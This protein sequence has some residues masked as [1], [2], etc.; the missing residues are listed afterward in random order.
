MSTHIDDIFDIIANKRVLCIGDLMLDRYI[1]G[2][3]KRISP[4][5]PIPILRK[6][7]EREMLGAVGN[8]ARNVVSLGGKVTL[9]SVV[10]DDEIGRRLA[11]LIA[12]EE[13][14]EGDLIPMRDRRTTLKT[15]FVANGQQLLRV[16][17][18]DSHSISAHDEEDLIRAIEE[19]TA[20]CDAVLVSDYA[21]G[22]VTSNVLAAV[23]KAA[24]RHGKP[25]VADPKGLDFER[26]G[27]VDLLKPNA[28]ELSAALNM[29]T[30]TDED[31]EKALNAASERYPAKAVLVTRSSKGLSYLKEDGKIVHLRSKPLEVY[32]V[33]GAGDTSL[34]ALGLGVA[35]GV[36]MHGVCEL[37]LAA[38]S[39][40]VTKVGTAA[41]FSEE[42]KTFVRGR[43]SR[44]DA[45]DKVMNLEEA[46]LQIATWKDAGRR[47]GFTN[48][49]FDILHAG[50][51]SLL[52][53]AR[54]R[55]DRLVVGLN[56]NESVRRLKGA[57]RPV[58][59]G[60]DRARVLSALEAVDL[61]VE[62]EDDTPHDLI[63]ALRP[64]LLVKG[65]DYT[66]DTIVGAQEVIGW[67]GDVH[68]AGLLDGRSTTGIL[69]RGSKTT[70]PNED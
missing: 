24:A 8:V 26:Y 5:A 69:A 16:D 42:V 64:D 7:D 58:N 44:L 35:G 25:V 3:V 39:V 37:A 31:I 6:G 61:V 52:R 15:R 17:V 29:P 4:E 1:Y 57:E 67:G 54:R 38:S 53:D 10:G 43:R 34:A 30:D 28:A 22:T 14:I 49:C 46:L 21:K 66:I 27:A 41:V 51:I 11:D 60:E 20:R 18:E 9:L 19:E 33:S 23:V 32:D 47:I 13:G 12:E 59:S 45:P 55:C 50:H 63:M 48:G 40:A 56:S 65:G 2:D 36:D 62:F 70:K 68:I